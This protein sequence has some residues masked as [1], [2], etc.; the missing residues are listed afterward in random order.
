M[1]KKWAVALRLT[2]GL[3]LLALI[4][5]FVDLREVVAVVTA[6]EPWY[7]VAVLAVMYLDRALMAYKW[8]PLLRDAG[9]HLPY[10]VL[11]RSYLIA[12]LAA[13]FLPSTVG[14]DL[15]RLY[16]L[17]R[18]KVDTRAVLASI[19]VERVIGFVAMLAVVGVG[20]GLGLYLLS[21]RWEELAAIVGALAVALL[22]GAGLALVLVGVAFGGVRR[23]VDRV[24]ARLA[25]YP[26]VGKLHQV[27]TLYT[28]Y[29]NRRRTLAVVFAWTLLEQMAPVVSVFILAQA[30]HVNVSFLQLVAIVPLV[31]LAARMPVSLDGL[32]VMEGMYVALFALVGVSVEESLLLAAFGRVLQNLPGLPFLVHYVF[33][34]RRAPPVA[35]QAQADLVETP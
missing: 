23:L 2:L 14:G 4:L 33:E 15:F 32:G 21:D 13:I 5:Y 10:S 28:Q 6:L 20:V 19:V 30:L 8:R 12:P 26:L 24:A 1:G 27:Y 7:L 17:S 3:G 11:L 18:Y 35:R 25:R 9:V 22:L 34:R 16:H 31:L 29:L